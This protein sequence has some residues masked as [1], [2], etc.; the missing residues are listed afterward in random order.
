[1]I[2]MITIA[3]GLLTGCAG[4]KDQ[5]SC[6]RIDRSI[7]VL[8]AQAVPSATQLPCVDALPA[9]WTYNGFQITDGLVRF[10]LDSDRAGLRSVETDLSASC[11]VSDAVEVPPASDELG[12]RTYQR[13]TSITPHFTGSRFIVFPGGCIT[14]HYTFSAGASATLV[15]EAEAAL[16]MVPRQPIVD[17]VQKDLGLSLCGAGAQTC[18]G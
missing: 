10:W 8:E 13:P 11:D 5:P 18:A 3:A 7:F 6:A 15:L 2:A 12:T 14:H 17:M 9:G 16:S 1:M 4:A